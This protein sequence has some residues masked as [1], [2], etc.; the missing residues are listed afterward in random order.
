MKEKLK[1]PHMWTGK[2]C[3]ITEPHV[4]SL[5]GDCPKGVVW[6]PASESEVIEI[7][8]VV[9]F[10]ALCYT[11]NVPPG[12][13]PHAFENASGTTAPTLRRND[14]VRDQEVT[15][16]ADGGSPNPP[17]PTTH[18]QHRMREVWFER[19]ASTARSIETPRR[20]SEWVSVCV[21]VHRVHSNI[22]K[23]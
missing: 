14:P 20:V 16:C 9:G 2:K 1:T 6:A 22:F 17:H 19:R 4:I 3:A 12:F 7:S 13:Q 21:R 23:N 5:R 8:C 15:T 10:R 11:W 18:S